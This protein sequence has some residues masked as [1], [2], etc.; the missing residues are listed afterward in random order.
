MKIEIGLNEE[1][2]LKNAI[3]EL[4]ERQLGEITKNVKVSI[5]TDRINFTADCVINPAEQNM[6]QDEKNRNLFLFYKIKQYNI[7]KD[8]FMEKIESIIQYKVEDSSTQFSQDGTRT[9]T[10]WTGNRL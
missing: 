10:L 7:V 3:C 8:N 6:M 5:E 2:K 1:R 9:I 4:L